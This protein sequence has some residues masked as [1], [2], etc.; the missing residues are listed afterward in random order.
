MA[1]ESVSFYSWLVAPEVSGSSDEDVARALRA[2]GVISVRSD[3]ELPARNRW[4]PVFLVDDIH[5]ITGLATTEAYTD[6]A[7]LAQSAQ[8]VHYFADSRGATT[9][10][11]DASKG[12]LPVSRLGGTNVDYVTDDPAT[13]AREQGDALGLDVYR[14]VSDEF[15]AHL[16]CDGTFVAAGVLRFGSTFEREAASGWLCYL[17]VDDLDA[18]MTRALAAGA[19]V[20]VPASHSGLN[21]YAVLL[22]PWGTPFGLSAD[23]AGDESEDIWLEGPAGRVPLSAFAT[24]M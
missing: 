18:A 19:R 8:P 9:R 24:M 6:A 13:T 20:L 21:R 22:D 23:L 3:T 7:A 1:E 4:I 15:D 12:A 10:V 16:L 17:G 5:G 2:K 14:M 11:T